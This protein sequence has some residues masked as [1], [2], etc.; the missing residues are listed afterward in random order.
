MQP[1]EGLA[2]DETQQP[3]DELDRSA[4]NIVAEHSW[5]ATI[6]QPADT[7]M[8]STLQAPLH[9]VMT[10][11]AE[12]WDAG[13]TVAVRRA[14]GGNFDCGGRWRPLPGDVHAPT[15]NI[16]KPKMLPMALASPEQGQQRLPET[17]QV[18]PMP[19]SLPAYTAVPMNSNV[20][21]ATAR[22]LGLLLGDAA[23]ENGVLPGFEYKD[24]GV[25]IFGNAVAPT[26]SSSAGQAQAMDVS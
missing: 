11:A 1:S 17:E 20:E 12:S 7:E 25:D 21:T 24:T 19:V 13:Y 10:N 6:T 3:S 15:E 9:N 16:P 5:H 2:G 8:P 4:Q 23:P 22:W 26:P 14:S 18:P